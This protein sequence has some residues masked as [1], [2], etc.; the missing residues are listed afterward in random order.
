MKKI[1]R[2]PE[3]EL[4][5]MMVLWRNPSPMIASEIAKELADTRGWK[6]ATIHVLLNRLVERGF[7]SCDRSGY[8]HPFTPIITKEEYRRGEASVM[9]KRFFGGSAKNMIAALLNT[10]GLS[11]DDLDE[12]SDILKRRKGGK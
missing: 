9:M 5:I 1:E 4:E 2:I 10:D 8:R 7:V 12:L 3:S 6:N 11:D